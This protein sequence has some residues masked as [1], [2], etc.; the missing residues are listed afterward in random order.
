MNPQQH[1]LVLSSFPLHTRREDPPPSR[2]CD[3]NTLPD[4]PTR[5]QPRRKDRPSGPQIYL[6]EKQRRELNDDFD[7]CWTAEF[8]DEG[9]RA[10]EEDVMVDQME[11]EAEEEGQSGKEGVNDR[12]GRVRRAGRTA[13][14]GKDDDRRRSWSFCGS[15]CRLRV[16]C[17]RSRRHLVVRKAGRGKEKGEEEGRNDWRCREWREEAPLLSLSRCAPLTERC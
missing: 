2:P 7:E 6:Q 12:G 5:P 4:P 9:R 13:S 15:V 11:R 16:D 1:H 10:T 14:E 8:L 17:R 3:L